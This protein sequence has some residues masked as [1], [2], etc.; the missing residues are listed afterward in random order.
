MHEAWRGEARNCLWRSGLSTQKSQIY[1]PVSSCS[2]ALLHRFAPFP[3]DWVSGRR[4]NVCSE[5]GTDKLSW[6]SH[7]CP[8]QVL[9]CKS[10][11][12][13]F[14]TPTPR[15]YPAP[16][17]QSGC[18]SKHQRFPSNVHVCKLGGPKKIPVSECGPQHQPWE[19]RSRRTEA[20]TCLHLENP[21]SPC[22]ARV[23]CLQTVWKTWTV[24]WDH[25]NSQ[26]FQVGMLGKLLCH[27]DIWNRWQAQNHPPNTPVCELGFGRKVWESHWDH[28]DQSPLQDQC[29]KNIH[30]KQ[31]LSLV[32]QCL[33]PNANLETGKK[34]NPNPLKLSL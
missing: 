16:A 22:L 33:F 31:R 30:F 20:H 5:M 12:L 8:A 3:W 32:F 9:L 6:C 25:K 23:L 27:L 14:G 34:K 13:A 2:S 15:L 21:I 28:S 1:P 18:L 17:I 4:S 29:L 24:S 11:P 10:P 7:E 19:V 26:A